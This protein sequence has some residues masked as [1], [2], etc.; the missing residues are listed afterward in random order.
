MSP[1][2]ERGVEPNNA[3]SKDQKKAFATVREEY[4]KYV[5]VGT[6]CEMYV[7]LIHTGASTKVITL[8]CRF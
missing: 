5:T 1:I 6:C 4:A 3:A 2:R 8:V 7:I